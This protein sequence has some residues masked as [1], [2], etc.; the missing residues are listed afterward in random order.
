MEAK[1]TMKIWMGILTVAAMLTLSGCFELPSVYPLYTDQTA[2]AEP[3]LVG[4]WQT[5]DGKEQ[6][7]VK[8]T[9]DREYRFTYVDDKGEA[10]VW[11]MR[12]VKLGETLVAD[13]LAM[14]EDAGIPAH[15][16]LALSLE[17]GGLRAW[18][19]D[20]DKLRQLAGQEGLAYVSG[21]KSEGVLTA[22]TEALRAFLQKN[23]AEEMK[24]DADL[25]V[26]PLK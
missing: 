12:V 16:F 14:K 11:E 1:K 8:V 9:G 4:A 22:P 10:S 19:L 25:E 23:V 6:V 26:L 5:T 3:R 7:F 21:E 24:Q 15:H 20:S 18:F 17:G 13:L 2:V